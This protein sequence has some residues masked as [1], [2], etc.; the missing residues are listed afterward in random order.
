MRE[1]ANFLIKRPAR[2]HCRRSARDEGAFADTLRLMMGPD[3][4][5]ALNTCG[6]LLS[7]RGASSL[8]INSI[9]TRDGGPTPRAISEDQHHLQ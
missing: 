8:H 9:V 6:A 3:P 1:R 2:R 5:S 7:R 4:L